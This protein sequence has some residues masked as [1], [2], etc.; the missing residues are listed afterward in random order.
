[1]KKKQEEDGTLKKLVISSADSLELTDDFDLPQSV[2]SSM[3]QLIDKG[4]ADFLDKLPLR[5]GIFLPSAAV[6]L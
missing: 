6:F 5:F 2:L 4:S 1:M 3:L